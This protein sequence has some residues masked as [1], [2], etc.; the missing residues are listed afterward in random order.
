MRSSPGS[1]WIL[2]EAE[3]N[4]SR[5]IVCDVLIFMIKYKCLNKAG[6]SHYIELSPVWVALLELNDDLVP[7]Y[8]QKP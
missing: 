2:R 7:E 3:Y 6:G 1:M 4:R 5:G 8:P